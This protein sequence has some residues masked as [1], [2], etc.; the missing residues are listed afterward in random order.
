MFTVPIYPFL[1]TRPRIKVE[2]GNA[3]PIVEPCYHG[4]PISEKGS[5]V[6]YDWGGDIGR[7]IDSLT[8]FKTEIVDFLRSKE[9]IHMG[10]EADR[11]QVV[12]STKL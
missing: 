9:N 1:E 10:L 11:L 2:N 8:A 3:I 6:T 7:V 5:L 4:N 12:V